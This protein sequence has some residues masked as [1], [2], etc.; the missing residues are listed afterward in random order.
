VIAVTTPATA[1]APESSI[2]E[3]ILARAS[4][5][6]IRE[7]AIRGGMRTL[8]ESGLAALAAGKTTLE[9]VL[10]ETMR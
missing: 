10:R 6:D 3:A 9:E 2:R 4:T 7:A 8:R 5:A 1:A